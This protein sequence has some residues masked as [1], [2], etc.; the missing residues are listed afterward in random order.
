MPTAAAASDLYCIAPP[1]LPQE[2]LA[3][4]QE[5]LATM[6]VKVI[7]ERRDGVGHP[8]FDM[9]RQRALHLP[10]ELPGL[11]PELAALGEELQLV[12]RM[13]GPGL[14]HADDP[15]LQV[16]ELAR[17]GDPVAASELVW[18]LHARVHSRL[19]AH[20]GEVAARDGTDPALGR[21]LDRLEG[22]D[23]TGEDA[24]LRWLDS[25]VDGA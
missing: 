4:L 21:I 24:F 11:P 9:R 7:V 17:A 20:L 6:G 22:F 25:V 5:H 14:A 19:T 16:V 18:R 1:D 10:R 23:G 15:L 8:P 3:M 12:Q 2:H 13:P